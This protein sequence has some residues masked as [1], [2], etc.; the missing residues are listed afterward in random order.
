MEHVM[1]E[2]YNLPL[3][4]PGLTWKSVLVTLFI[5]NISYN[6]V[7]LLSNCYIVYDAIGT[8]GR[9]NKL[10][11]VQNTTQTTA[12]TPTTTSD[13]T[14]TTINCIDDDNKSLL[15]KS[16][17]LTNDNEPQMDEKINRNETASFAIGE[18]S[19]SNNTISTE[20]SPNTATLKNDK[21]LKHRRRHRKHR[22]I[23]D[24]T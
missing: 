4:L 10:P 18:E 13:T 1:P 22:T 21:V 7:T 19:E 5:M 20:N 12:P 16:A 24:D 14:E 11:T 17:E 15:K 23:K 6:F 9:E 2:L 3:E 8:I